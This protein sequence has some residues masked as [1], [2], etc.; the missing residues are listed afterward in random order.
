MKLL[1]PT[2]AMFLRMESKRTPMHIGAMMT[3]C[4][5]ADAGPGFVRELLAEFSRL[6]FLPPPF[7]CR[8]AHGPLGR[9]VPVWV[10]AKPDPEYHVRHSALP[11]PGG[12]RE[13]GALVARL[14]SNQLDFDRPLWEAHLV[15]GLEGGRFAFYF[16]AHHCAI[17]GMGA[18][19]NIKTWLSKD[20]DD[21]RGLPD[22]SRDTGPRRP[23]S[24]GERVQDL[25]GSV[26]DHSR[27]AP[28]LAGT[29]TRMGF[30]ANSTIRAALD[31]PRTLFN[32]PIT[33]QRRLAGQLIELERLKAVAKA[34]DAT[35][36]DV[37]LATLG[38]AVRRY[39]VEQDALPK[40]SVM[41]SVPIALE[42]AESTANAV[43]GFVAPLGTGEPDPKK[44]LELIRL[45]TDRAKKEIG[46]LSRHASTQFSVVGLAPLALG[47][48]TGTLAK[49]PP[50]F[51]F[52]VSNVPLSREPLYLNGARLEAIYPMSFLADGYALNVTLVSYDQ[53]MNFGFLGCRDAL[54]H[55][56]HLAVYTGEALAE[57]EGAV[58][59]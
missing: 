4:P 53:H 10:P 25:L 44:R 14:H 54:P 11:A 46:A 1:G 18:V 51:N 28:E 3:F 5:P 56:Q 59:A 36:N 15:E 22:L 20:P 39:L 7:D 47:Q 29:L 12:Q 40:N 27:A 42:R 31:T 52:T 19:R 34:A 9:V 45:A 43:A 35:I 58:R 50:F 21:R 49:L 30:G 32:V 6:S 57:L 33:Q 41:A 48:M 17:D 16:K 13:L 37:T 23:R 26:R 55:L 38:G 24:A 8:L 2:D